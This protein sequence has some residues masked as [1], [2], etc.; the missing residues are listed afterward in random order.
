MA[1]VNRIRFKINGKEYTVGEEVSSDVTLLD[2]VRQNAGLKGTK[3]MC[4]Q[5]GCG[6]CIVAVRRKP[7]ANVMSVNTCLVSVTSCYNWD[8][9]TI[10]KVGNRLDGYSP[11][12]K[13]LAENNGSQCG[14]CSP[15]WV[16]AL[17]SL[18]ENKKELSALEIEKSFGSNVC[19][20]TGYRPILEAFKKFAKDAPEY[21]VPDIEDLSPCQ[22]VNKTM[23]SNANTGD[24]CIVTKSDITENKII[25][26]TLD[27]G[28]NWVRAEEV[29]DIFNAL[30]KRGYASYMLVAGN[31]AKGAYPIFE[32]PQLLIDISGVSALKG[33][34][35]DQN[36]I[37]GAGTTLTE[38]LNICE[39]MSKTEEFAYLEAFVRH[40]HRVA[41]IAVRNLGTIAGNLM[42][43]YYHN[44]FASD[45]YLLLETVGAY[46][47]ILGRGGS[48]S[49]KVS[50]QEF[51][52]TD[53]RGKV[54]FNVLLPPLSSDYK[55]VTFKTTPRAQNAHATV[56][57]GFCYKYKYDNKVISARIVFG[58]LSSR[59]SRAKATEQSLIGKSLFLNET[60]QSA[61]DVLQ[62][63]LIVKEN[64]PEPPAPYRK[65]LALAL[66]YKGLLTLCPEEMVNSIYQS[67]KTDLRESRII[68]KG[69]QLYDTKPEL[70]PLTEPVIKKDALIQCAGEATYTYDE[71]ELPHEVHAAFV[72]STVPL[73]NIVSIHPEKALN[74][75]G[76]IAFYTAKDIPGLNSF[77]PTNEPT[78]KRNEEILCSGQIKYYNQPIAIVVAQSQ[79][80]ADRAAKVVEVSY[81][82]IKKPEID[83]KKTKKDPNRLMLVK[84]N[85]ASN[86]GNEIAHVIKHSETIYGQYH[87]T[88]ENIACVTYPVEDNYEVYATTQWPDAVQIIIS[89]VLNIH[90][91]RVD[92]Y[93]RRLGGAYGIK[94]T[95]STQV[96]AA[97]SLVAF[98]LNKPCRFIQS[99][100]TT[101]RAIG[102]R[103]PCSADF[104]VAINNDGVIQYMDFNIFEDN[105]YTVNEQL[106]ILGAK[107][108]NT[109]YDGSTW[110]FKCYDCTT[111]TAKNTWCR[112]PA[113]LETIAMVEK[114]MERISYEV[115]KDPAEVRL[116]NL[117]YKTHGVLKEMYETLKLNSDYIQRRINVNNFNSTNRWKKRGLRFS[118][119]RWVHDEPRYFDINISVYHGDGSVA[120]THGGVE[121]GQGINTKA[122]QVCAYLLNI[123]LD[124]IQVKATNT[125]AAPNGSTSGGSI[126][127]QNIIVGVHRACKQLLE[128]LE[129]IIKDMKNATW[130]EIIQKAF[131]AN[132]DL[133]SHGFVALNLQY[134]NVYG[135]TLSEVEVD[136]L[137]GESE[138]LRVDLLEDAGQSVSP[139]IDVGQVEGAFVM[140]I[141]YWLTEDLV[142]DSGTGELLTDRT[143]NYYVPQAR[144]IPFD[145]RIYFKKDSFSNDVIF[146]SKAI[147]EPPMCMAVSLTFAI[148]EALVA[149]RAHSGIHSTDW[150]EIDGPYT[151]S[152]V[153]MAAATN[154][155]QFKFN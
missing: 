33:Y 35:V 105:G 17:Y 78:I 125:I 64:P 130:A 21:S 74:I 71:P 47:T 134:Y 84:S 82:N 18:L 108:Y 25:E 114:I 81:T 86:K 95:R 72:L 27:D 50:M 131:D 32:Y 123:P 147:G 53:I 126:T 44:E 54:I 40:L 96:A 37:I 60:L 106:A 62:R 89:K 26:F 101:M 136:I 149:A 57:A 99:I 142:Y 79:E 56:N 110:N 29:D 122:A 61:L 8:I 85:D 51:L 13:T 36:L 92:V 31:T 76:V 42:L 104:E 129:P 150:F 39:M 113:T 75:P 127:S 120:I 23:N 34:K 103:F 91:N 43:K 109:C 46:I 3:F 77:T 5:G 116:S 107:I 117:D 98:K 68:S 1:D 66:F 112:S 152:K 102:K 12:Q 137:T 45:I 138:I 19:R 2:F 141:G 48:S 30:S 118:F 52:R 151:P 70:W 20:C 22:S 65:Q 153:C 11:I 144:D 143:W 135:V 100:T 73:G 4:R 83:V 58:G 9:T 67:G 139:K 49:Q 90:Q 111:D 7:G 6:A 93:V 115:S 38:F 133:Q 140:G 154:I 121:M 148:R 14:Y 87:F 24:W 10:E 146:G 97:C 63:E 132:I 16:M 128:R 59:F 80:I 119:L 145:F 124:K 41:H 15:G 28:K 155:K 55:V 94:I 69:S 88:M